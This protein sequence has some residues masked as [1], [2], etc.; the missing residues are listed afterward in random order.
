M[1][2]LQVLQPL[3]PWFCP[4][5]IEELAEVHPWIKQHAVPQEIDTQVV[6]S[7]NH[8]P[9]TRPSTDLNVSF[10]VSQGCASCSAA[11]GV[12]RSPPP[13]APDSSSPLESPE[14]DSVGALVDT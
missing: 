10:F 1:E 6:Q 13:A 5:Q 2:K 14:Q 9:F 11:A 12:A 8:G 7:S 3:Q 4:E